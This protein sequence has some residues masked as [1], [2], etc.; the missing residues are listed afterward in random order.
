MATQKIGH[1]TLVGAGPGAIDLISVR[2][3]RCIQQADTILYDALVDPALLDYAPQAEKVFVGKRAG[4]HYKA[5]EEINALIQHYLLKGQHVV[6]LKGGDPLVFGRGHEE[7]EAVKTIGGTSSIV[8]GISSVTGAPASIGIPITRRGVS[9]SFWVITG[10]TASGALSTDLTLAAQSS[11][12]ILILMGLQKLSL[13]VQLFKMYRKENEPIAIIQNASR[14][15][16]KQV[17]G[18]LQNI[19][20][21]VEEEKIGTPGIILVGEVVKYS[22]LAIHEMIN[23]EAVKD[24]G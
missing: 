21:L 7:I 9:D 14:D 1:L 8:P 15:D 11:A 13:I 12:T 3:L 19:E 24:E 22:P 20:Q 17:I 18:T 23:H 6:R 2:G 10:T 4:Q 16:Q 5:Q